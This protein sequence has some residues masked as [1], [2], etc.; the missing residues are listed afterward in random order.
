MLEVVFDQ[1]SYEFGVGVFVDLSRRRVV[2]LEASILLGGLVRVVL[3]CLEN[4][5]SELGPQV[6]KSA[7][8]LEILNHNVLEVVHLKIN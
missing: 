6:T 7:F 5:G 3:N 4:A 8:L 1:E 2:P